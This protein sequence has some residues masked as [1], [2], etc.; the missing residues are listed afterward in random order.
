MDNMNN[1]PICICQ[2]IL[3]Q[4]NRV[5][6]GNSCRNCWRSISP[7]HGESRYRCS[8]SNCVY[9]RISG[10]VYYICDQC[11]HAP[12]IVNNDDNDMNLVEFVCDKVSSSINRIS[13]V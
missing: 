1:H 9:K 3:K 11:Y 8:S 7:D 2:N 10:Q 12:N 13:Y 5:S 4:Y 6:Q